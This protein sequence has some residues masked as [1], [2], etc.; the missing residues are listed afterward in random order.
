M[1][2]RFDHLRSVFQQPVERPKSASERDRDREQLRADIAEGQRLARRQAAAADPDAAYL[3]HCRAQALRIAN[4]GQARRG[5]PLLKRLVDD[6]P[7]DADITDGDDQDHT[8]KKGK[9]RAKPA[10]IISADDDEQADNDEPR[11]PVDEG[12]DDFDSDDEK[13]KKRGSANP[14]LGETISQYW[15][16]VDATAAAIVAAAKKVRGR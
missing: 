11:D 14:A 12:G 10:K 8:P 7:D 4:A 16:R 2:G 6:E 13:K 1:A 9:K 5:M 15:A 3:A